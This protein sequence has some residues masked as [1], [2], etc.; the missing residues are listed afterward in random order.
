MGRT[1]TVAL[2]GLVV[3][4]IV[5]LIVFGDDG[6]GLELRHVVVALL[7]A[8]VGALIETTRARRGTRN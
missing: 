5:S 2:I 3:G 1:V 8:A 4:V 7:G 6:P